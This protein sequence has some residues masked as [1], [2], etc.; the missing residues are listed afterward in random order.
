M[1]LGGG[2]GG[3]IPKGGRAG[4]GEIPRD[5]ARGGRDPKGFG[6][7]GGGANPWDTGVTMYTNVIVCL[8]K[9]PILTFSTEQVQL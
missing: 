1:S 3:E 6:P 7:P 8:S 2:G 5:L 9:V 4:G